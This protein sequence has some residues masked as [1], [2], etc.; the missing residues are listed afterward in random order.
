[1]KLRGPGDF[2]GA[3]QHGL[4]TLHAA[5]LSVD[6]R[7]LKEA[8][9]TGEELLL[10]DPTLKKPEHAALKRQVGRMFEETGGKLN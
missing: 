1:M 9:E 7:L 4:P 8:Q 2:F 3:R 6:M 10:H 5:D